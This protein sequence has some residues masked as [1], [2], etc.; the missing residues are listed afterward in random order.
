MMSKRARAV[1]LA[2][3]LAAGL[4]LP[5]VTAGMQDLLMGRSW[6]VVGDAGG[7][8]YSG[9]LHNRA[10]ALNAWRNG[11]NAVRAEQGAAVDAPDVLTELLQ[12]GLLPGNA[13]EWRFA[14]RKL[15]L[16][17]ASFSARY[18]YIQVEGE[19]DSARL[20][21][22]LDAESGRALLIEYRCPP[23]ELT[24][25]HTYQDQELL[26]FAG[27]WGY[28]D[29]NETGVST[30]SRTGMC[31]MSANIVGTRYTVSVYMM[32]VHGLLMYTLT[33]Q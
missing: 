24:A 27:Y 7:Y 33:A 29:V 28:D 18:D 20:S 3:A 8:V 19:T 12:S 2:M 14:A 32:P 15:T 13:G 23:D 5:L 16:L 22:I 21:A 26:R 30:Y 17:P 31:S 9:T 6:E 1:L 11:S 10:L 25:W 4:L